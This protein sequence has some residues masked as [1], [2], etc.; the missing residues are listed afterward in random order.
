M[1]IL[2]GFSLYLFF[3]PFRFDL[4]VNGGG[5]VTLQFQRSPLQ[6]MTRTSYL[7]WNRIT[8]INPVVMMPSGTT[9]AEKPSRQGGS[10]SLWDSA[11]SWNE[12]EDFSSKVRLNRV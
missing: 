7:P 2:Q 9:R 3:S 6:A 10:G 5:A 1:V 12:E 4:A 11:T 8:V